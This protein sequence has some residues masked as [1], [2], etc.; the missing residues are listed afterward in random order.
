[1]CIFLDTYIR[2]YSQ[3]QQKPPFLSG[4]PLNHRARRGICIF[5]PKI[6]RDSLACSSLLSLRISQWDPKHANCYQQALILETT[7]VGLE[8]EVVLASA[9]TKR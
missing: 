1:M 4:D 8:D 9:F 2:K 5:S 3:Q 7:V 6:L